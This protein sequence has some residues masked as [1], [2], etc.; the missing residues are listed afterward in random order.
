MSSFC[1]SSLEHQF[2][3]AEDGVS[4]VIRLGGEVLLLELGL[5]SGRL[6]PIELLKF[7]RFCK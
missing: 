2:L 7:C 4:S 5:D 3:E 6:R 1:D